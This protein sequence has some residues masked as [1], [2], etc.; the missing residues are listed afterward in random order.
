[1]ILFAV[2]EMRDVLRATRIKLINHARSH[3]STDNALPD[4]AINI[5]MHESLQG[6]ARNSS[7]PS[8]IIELVAH[9]TEW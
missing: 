8:E 9:E 6:A 2:Y 4:L 3:P 1:M 7:L 5:Q